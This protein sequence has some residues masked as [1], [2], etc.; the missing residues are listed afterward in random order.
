MISGF[1]ELIIRQKL[2]KF[3]ENNQIALEDYHL[4]SSKIDHS[5]FE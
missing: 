3:I 4:I 2:I 1:I 5:N